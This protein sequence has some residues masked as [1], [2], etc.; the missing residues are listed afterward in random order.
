MVDC[1]FTYSLN[2]SWDAMYICLLILLIHLSIYSLWP[3]VNALSLEQG[4]AYVLK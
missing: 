3:I 2:L 4:P 1:S